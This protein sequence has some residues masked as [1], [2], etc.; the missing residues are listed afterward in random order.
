MPTQNASNSEELIRRLPGLAFVLDGKGLIRHWNHNAEL[1]TGITGNDLSGRSLLTLVQEAEKA[2]MADRLQDAA[3]TGQA[4]TEIH[5]VLKDHALRYYHFWLSALQTADG[6]RL[7]ALGHDVTERVQAESGLRD[8]EARL[9]EAQSV[10]HLGNWNLDLVSNVLH[11][12]DEIYRIF[13]IDPAKFGASYEAF[14]N[15]IHPDDREKVNKAYTD[16]VASRKPYSIDHRLRM[17]D[18]RIKWVHERCVTLYDENWRPLRSIGTVQDITERKKTEWALAERV[19]EQRCL[20]LVSALANRPDLD[21]PELLTQSL[22]S[23]VAAFQYPEITRARMLHRDH[24]HQSPDFRTSPWRLASDLRVDGVLEGTLEVYY[25]QERLP[26]V[27]GPFLAEE[28]ALLD[29]VA[30]VLGQMLSIRRAAQTARERLRR[31]EVQASALAAVVSSPAIAAGEVEQLAREIT[32]HA[33]RATGVERANVWL[34]NTDETELHCIDLYEKTPARHSA[35][36]ELTEAQFR[37]EF[38]ALKEKPYVD[39]DDALTD[40]RTAGYTESYLKPLRITSMLDAVIAVS[41]RHLGLVCLEH[42]DQPHHWEEDEINFA[43][44]LTVKLALAISNRDRVQAEHALQRSVRALKTLSAGNHA[45]LHATSEEGLYQ[46]M[47]RIAVE[48]GGYR[49]AWVGLAEHDAA[50]TVRPVASAG[51]DGNYIGQAHIT[52]AD[53]ERGR[54]PT[55]LAIRSG[56]PV[57]AQDF[58]HDPKLAPWREQAHKHGFESSVALPLKTG[59][60]TFGAFMIY[61]PEPD[62]FHGD[63][64]AM[65][66]EMANDLAFGIA[67]LRLRKVNE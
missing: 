51:S 33:V 20:H 53:T 46:E 62:A 23:L 27:E 6:L 19:K 59:S 50:K 7:L 61:A 14:L 26:A 34:F 37:N 54:G 22:T 16:S 8:S 63:E 39:A 17:P 41:G 49:M 3:A 4:Q 47:C 21:E 48:I 15:V 57:I 40:P 18:G 56:A 1:L 45:L 9:A 43:H 60:E 28:R 44:Q 31:V 25:L 64:M 2:H 13:E 32:E 11:W 55:G 36:M 30:G 12:S 35:G 42:V 38:R 67:I 66:T 24:V 58:A 52:W 5:L 29:A 10:A 65:L